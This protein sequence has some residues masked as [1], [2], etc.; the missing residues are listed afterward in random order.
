MFSQFPWNYQTNYVSPIKP[1]IIVLAERLIFPVGCI[2][3][4]MPRTDIR[5]M[6]KGLL[7]LA[8]IMMLSEHQATNKNL[9]PYKQTN[10]VFCSFLEAPWHTKSLK[11]HIIPKIRRVKGPPNRKIVEM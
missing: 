9:P 6:A 4:P 1:T 10:R 8:C 3:E 2:E 7:P 5:G 11:N